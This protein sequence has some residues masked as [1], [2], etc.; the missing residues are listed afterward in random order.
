MKEVKKE[1]HERQIYI[2]FYF[3]AEQRFGLYF[4]IRQRFS[5]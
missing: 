3:T 1:A 4:P 2:I 5:L